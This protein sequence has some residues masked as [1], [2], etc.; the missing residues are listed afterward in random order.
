MKKY[1]LYS[2]TSV[3]LLTLIIAG[4]TYAFL[5]SSVSTSDNSI[6]SN[7][8]SLNVIYNPGQPINESL[9]VSSSKEDGYNTTVKIKLAPN[10]AKAKTNLY[11]HINEIT[12][13][14]AIPGFIWE[15]YG[16]RNGKQVIYN[17]GNFNGYNSTTK[18]KIPIVEDYQLS[19]D[20]TTFTVY[21]WI[22]G[23]KTDNDVLGGTFSGYIGATS[24]EFSATLH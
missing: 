4:S 15:V 6:F 24:E 14:I 19:E 1:M 3:L 11:I 21:F 17:K 10:S 13:N 20:E 7:T 22:D 16:Y 5:S 2:I 18:N 12:Q 23:S 8:A 9:S